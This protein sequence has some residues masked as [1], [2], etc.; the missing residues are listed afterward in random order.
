MLVRQAQR[1]YLDRTPIPTYPSNQ[2]RLPLRP[3]HPTLALPAHPVQQD[4]L[5]I[6]RWPRKN[7]MP[8]TASFLT[9]LPKDATRCLSLT[10]AS[11][12]R[13]SKASEPTWNRSMSFT[14]LQSKHRSQ[15]GLCE[16]LFLFSCS[17][18]DLHLAYIGA[19][20]VH[21]GTID[22]PHTWRIRICS[23]SISP[24]H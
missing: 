24:L 6:A 2:H 5:T 17:M 21:H 8:T 11:E 19:P 7:P 16:M 20:C 14:T 13:L 22:H 4:A 3:H 15:L 23:L 10:L 12:T 1:D 9:R 18:T